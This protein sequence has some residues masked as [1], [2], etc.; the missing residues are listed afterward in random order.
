MFISLRVALSWKLSAQYWANIR[1]FEGIISIADK[2]LKLVQHEAKFMGSLPSVLKIY[3]SIEMLSKL[4]GDKLNV[5][6]L[7]EVTASSKLPRVNLNVS[8][9]TEVSQ[10]CLLRAQLEAERR[11]CGNTGDTLTFEEFEPS[12]RELGATL[13]YFRTVSAR[14]FSVELRLS[15]LKTLK[16]GYAEFSGNAHA[17]KEEASRKAFARSAADSQR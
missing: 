9:F 13:L 3:L 10:T 11:F 8:D 14:H 7:E 15:A 2:A 4:R 1:Y 16:E 6:S 17:F 12:A 5:V